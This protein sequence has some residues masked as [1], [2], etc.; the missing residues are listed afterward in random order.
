MIRRWF[1]WA[2]AVRQD[3]EL[4]TI[5]H[6]THQKAGSQWIANILRQCVPDRII[7]A[8]VDE[9]QITRRRIRAGSVYTPAYITRQKLMRRRPP[10]NSRIF[11]VLRDLRDAL[12][13][14]YLA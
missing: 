3:Q 6:V 14:G 7:E 13:S 2:V 9:T 5:F 12:V 4:P 11:I 1:T 10:A 8:E